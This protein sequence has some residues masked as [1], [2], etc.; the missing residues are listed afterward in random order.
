MHQTIRLLA[1]AVL[2]SVLAATADPAETPAKPA[3]TAAEDGAK[4]FAGLKARSIGPAVTSGRVMAIAV[5][6]RDP[7][8]IYIGSASGG[9]WKTVNGG[10]SWQPIFDREGSYSIGW[11]TLDPGNPHVGWVGTGERNS[12]RSVGYGDGVYKSQDGG[13]TWTKMGLAASEHIGRVV[14]VDAP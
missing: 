8:V 13:A 9:V 6:P 5:H 2:V 1:V 4:V 3:G 7:G 14:V 11:V 10:A 12:Q